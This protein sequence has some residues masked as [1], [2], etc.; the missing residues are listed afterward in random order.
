MKEAALQGDSIA[1]D[2]LQEAGEGIGLHLARMVAVVDPEII[3][4]GGEAVSFGDLLFDPMRKALELNCFTPPPALVPDERDNFWSSGAAA[5]ATQG[6]FN[7]EMT[8]PAFPA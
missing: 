5:L 6:L 7:F 8:T 3:I 1:R 4:V 2:I